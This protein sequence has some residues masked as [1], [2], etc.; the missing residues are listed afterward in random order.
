MCGSRSGCLLRRHMPVR[1]VLRLPLIRRSP[2]L[3]GLLSW[4]SSIAP[5]P[6]VHRVHS[7][8]APRGLPSARELPSSRT[9]SVP[10]VPPSFDGLLHDGPCGF[11]APRSRSWGSP[12]FGHDSTTRR[13]S[14]R[15][16]P[17]GADPSK[18]SPPWQRSRV[19]ACF[20]FSSLGRPS[21]CWCCHPQVSE[22]P[23]TSRPCSARESVAFAPRCRKA[24]ARCSL[25]F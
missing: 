15:A 25:G 18:R 5:P 8:L 22:S 3:A 13:S 9:R 19:S 1:A 10:A 11:V 14:R 4:G 20:A 6:A 21:A 23:S 17:A 24:N 12:G 2:A 16:R 7:R